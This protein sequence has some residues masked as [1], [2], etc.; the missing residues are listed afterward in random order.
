VPYN[1]DLSFQSSG[2]TSDEI[3][4]VRARVIVVH[5]T[6]GPGAGLGA[7]S[8]ECVSYAELQVQVERL[9]RELDS[10]LLAGRHHFGQYSKSI[11]RSRAP[12]P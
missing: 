5:T 9:E 6:G 11:G 8:P 10:I 1:L 7:I 2:A 3:P 12:A 4:F